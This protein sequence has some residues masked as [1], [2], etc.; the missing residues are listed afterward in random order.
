M[1]PSAGEAYT[2]S[3][4]SGPA[5]RVGSRIR[6]GYR[7]GGHRA[8]RSCEDVT[9]CHRVRTTTLETSHARARWA[10]RLIGNGI[11]DCDLEVTN[12]PMHSHECSE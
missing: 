5:Q 2:A 4:A 10:V 3:I 9:E 6:M 8:C 12:E 1:R 7:Q 11:D